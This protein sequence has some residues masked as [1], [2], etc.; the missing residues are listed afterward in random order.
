MSEAI[1]R[2]IERTGARSGQVHAL[3][4]GLHVLG[5]ARVAGVDVVLVHGDVSRRHAELD[6]HAE[7][8]RVRDLGSKNGVR[9]A[10]RAVTEVELRHGSRIRLGEL[11]LELEHPGSRIDEL[12]SRSGEA[13]VRRPLSPREVLDAGTRLEP[14]RSSSEAR[15]A[16]EPSLIAPLLAAGLFAALLVV[17]LVFG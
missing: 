6:V 1:A 3:R 10:G 9:V 12:L 17:L 5:R 7:G 16:R 8:A 14:G 13:T 2:L 11:E 4:V 15:R